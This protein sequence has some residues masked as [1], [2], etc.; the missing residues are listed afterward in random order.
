MASQ[1]TT[2]QTRNRRLLGFAVRLAVLGVCFATHESFKRIFAAARARKEF[3]AAVT[4]DDLLD[5]TGVAFGTAGPTD[6]V[7]VIQEAGESVTST[8]SDV[9]F[10]C[11]PS[12]FTVTLYRLGFRQISVNGNI[13]TIPPPESNRKAAPHGKVSQNTLRA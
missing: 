13:R 9:D 3:A 4:V 1:I 2:H 11:L 5:G 7:F 12:D 6:T 8:E 10:F